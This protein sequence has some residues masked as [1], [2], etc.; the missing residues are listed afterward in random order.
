MPSTLATPRTDAPAPALA[1]WR[2]ALGPAHV[3]TADPTRDRYARSTQAA[4][5]RPLAVLRPGS[6]ADVQAAVRVARDHGVAL[7]PVSGG[8]NWGYGDACAPTEHQVVL[9]LGRMNEVHE[10]DVDLGYAVIGPGVTQGQLHDYLAARELP[11]WTDVTGAGLRGS[12]VGNTLERGFGHTPYGDHFGH[13]AGYDVVLGTGELVR[14]GF[15]HYAAARARYVY[16]PGVGPALDGLFAQS[17]LGVVVRMGVWLMPRPRHMRAFAFTIDDPAGVGAAVDAVRELRLAGV[18][19][20]VVHVG[21]DLRVAA[22]RRRYPREAAGG[23]ALD[24]DARRAMR[25]ELGLGSWNGSGA[26]YGS[27]AMTRA[28]AREVRR[29]LGP[30]TSRLLFFDDR[31]A[32]LARGVQRVA[33]RLG[34]GGSRIERLGAVDSALGLLKGIPSDHYLRGAGWRAREAPRADTLDPLDNRWGFN[35][36]AP[37][38]PARGADVAAYND[39]C[40]ATFAEFDLEPQVTVVFVSP[41]AVCCVTTVSYERADVAE[42]ARGQACYE[43]LAE[44]AMAAGFPPYR[45]SAHAMDALARG[46]E[47]FWPVAARLK[48]ALDPDGVL[49]PGRYAPAGGASP[50]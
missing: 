13:S 15:G 12:I 50:R 24:P 45:T 14:T 25:R 43:A 5:T 4:A 17:N 37:I 3:D 18:V 46:S 21:N 32:R 11:L 33:A 31:T 28:A 7:Y 39:L 38:V 49:A 6:T 23:H 10:V 2:E 19:D 20:S 47:G 8:I 44:R 26:L 1:A 9:D 16:K 27:R 35:W 29:V 41:R 34:I 40:E 36:Y 22:A 30:H 42:A 48:R